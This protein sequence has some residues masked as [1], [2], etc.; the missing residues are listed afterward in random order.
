MIGVFFSGCRIDRRYPLIF[1]RSLHAAREA[2]FSR[3]REYTGGAPI[4]AFCDGWLCG[5]TPIMQV[6]L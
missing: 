1:A 6:L 2:A 5:L 4:E 3:A